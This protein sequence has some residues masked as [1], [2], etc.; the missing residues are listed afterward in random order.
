MATRQTMSAARGGKIV[1]DSGRDDSSFKSNG[2]KMPK[3]GGS[4]SN[5]SHSLSGASANMDDNG[6]KK[7]KFD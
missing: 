6:N 2:Q 5:L 7:N 4:T 3:F 1:V